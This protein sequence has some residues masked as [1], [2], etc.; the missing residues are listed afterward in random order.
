MEEGYAQRFDRQSQY[1]ILTRIDDAIEWII[2][3]L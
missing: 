1:L 2:F 3:R